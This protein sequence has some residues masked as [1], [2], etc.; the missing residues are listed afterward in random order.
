[1]RRAVRLWSKRIGVKVNRLQIRTMSS[2]WASVS[3]AG[4]LTL[5]AEL[6]SLPRGLGEFVVVHE[7]V[8]LLAPNHGRLH[9]S[10][11]NSYLPDWRSRQDALREA[12]QS[13]LSDRAAQT[14]SPPYAAVP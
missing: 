14:I 12:A 6:L 8:H 3:T 5:N 2:K 7:L 1:M 4:Q 9:T 13:T 11:M 10:F